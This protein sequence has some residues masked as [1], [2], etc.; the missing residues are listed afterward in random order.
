[1]LVAGRHPGVGVAEKAHGKAR[2]DALDKQ[3]GGCGV[4]GVMKP[5]LADTGQVQY[6]VRLGR[7]RLLADRAAVLTSE[8]QPVVAPSA[9]RLGLFGSLF[10]GMAA[11]LFGHGQGHAPPAAG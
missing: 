11:K 1:M 6:P 2:R 9:A 5:G 8:D 4:A 3:Q 7:V 10:N